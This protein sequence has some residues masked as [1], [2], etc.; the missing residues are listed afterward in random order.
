MTLFPTSHDRDTELLS[1][2]L[3]NQLSPAERA[4]LERRLETD[5]QLRAAL[6]GLR[7][8][9]TTLGALPTVK[10]PRNFTLTPAMVGQTTRTPRRVS[11]LIPA[12]NWATAL[13]AIV[14]AVLVVTERSG[15]LRLETA[16]PAAAPE[17]AVAQESLPVTEEDG[18]ALKSLTPTPEAESLAAPALEPSAEPLAGESGVGAG[19]GGAPIPPSGE[20]LTGVGGGAGGAGGDA[21]EGVGITAATPDVLGYAAD[22]NAITPTADESLRVRNAAETA[23]PIPTPTPTQTPTQPPPLLF[24]ELVALALLIIFIVMGLILRR[25]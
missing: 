18:A 11:P 9:K 19:A 14:L 22:A 4:K 15:G 8:A 21:S 6:D 3:D 20:P 24:A 1:A 17:V 12:L 23:T 25:L 16:Q 13:A 5:S 2:Y 10:P 7:Y